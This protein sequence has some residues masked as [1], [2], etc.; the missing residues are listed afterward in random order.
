MFP[1]FAKL[2]DDSTWYR[3]ETTVGQYT[4]RAIPAI[5]TGRIPPTKETAGIAHNYPQSL[6]TLLGGTY[7]M[8][9]REKYEQLC[10]TSLCTEP[11]RDNT[12][13]YLVKASRKVLHN[14]VDVDRKSWDRNDGFRWGA[15][16][17]N[18]LGEPPPASMADDFVSSLQPSDGPRLDYADLFLPHAPWRFLEDFRTAGHDG[19]LVEKVQNNGD[20]NVYS[21][22]RQLHL[23]QVQATDTFIGRVIDRLEEIGEYDDTLFVATADHGVAFPYWR[24]LT[25]KNS[26]YVMWT[27]LLVKEPGQSEGRIDDRPMQ[28]IDVLPTMA[29]ILGVKIPWKIDGLSALDSPRP[30]GRRPIVTPPAGERRRVAVLRRRFGI[31]EDAGL[32]LDT[33]RR[34]S[35]PAPLPHRSVRRAHRQKY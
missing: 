34:R 8:Y 33:A 18:L 9:A 35:R 5:L 15:D 20:P 19:A 22:G 24:A 25:A 17:E 11:K 28:S 7:D 31:P 1:N 16:F 10:P 4:G 29:D 30:E 21:L 27:P 13:G 6:F 32:E 3:N 14:L 2:A 26:P 23:L 12:V